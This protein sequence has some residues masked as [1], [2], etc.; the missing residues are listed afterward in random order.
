M[1]SFPDLGQLGVQAGLTGAMTL[2]VTQ[3]LKAITGWTERKAIVATAVVALVLALLAWGAT[4]WSV[5]QEAWQIITGW[6]SSLAAASGLYGFGRKQLS[7]TNGGGS[8][9][10]ATR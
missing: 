5:L 2:L 9:G 1:E 4:H 3:I 8:D 10:S 7:S 6:L